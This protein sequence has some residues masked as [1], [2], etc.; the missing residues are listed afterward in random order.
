MCKTTSQHA[1]SQEITRLLDNGWSYVLLAAELDIHPA[2][3]RRWH[4]FETS[5]QQG[6]FV[7]R[8]LRGLR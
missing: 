1:I 7:L 8:K 6:P 5:S 4:F 3:V 2:S